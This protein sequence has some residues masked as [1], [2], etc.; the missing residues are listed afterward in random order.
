[1][2]PILSIV[3]RL[4]RG[5]QWPS[6]QGT[7]HPGGMAQ[8][9]YECGRGPLSGLF[10]CVYNSHLANDLDEYDYDLKDYEHQNI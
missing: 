8:S 2:I 4:V 9:L 6:P 5:I 1:M 7:R 10:Q 3:L